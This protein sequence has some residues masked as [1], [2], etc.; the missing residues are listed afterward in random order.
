MHAIITRDI[1]GMTV[2]AL[3][4]AGLIHRRLGKLLL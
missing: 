3:L 4:Q 2:G 1:E